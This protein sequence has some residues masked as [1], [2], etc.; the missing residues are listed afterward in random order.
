ME[1]G[2]NDLVQII[3]RQQVEIEMLRR[4]NQS[5][6]S[7]LPVPPKSDPEDPEPQDETAP[8]EAG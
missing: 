5:L 6:R 1:F 8:S 3:G 2:T 7:A 4:Q